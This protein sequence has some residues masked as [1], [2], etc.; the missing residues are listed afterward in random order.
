MFFIFFDW[1]VDFLIFLIF[2]SGKDFLLFHVCFD[3]VY[4]SFLLRDVFFFFFFIFVFSHDCVFSDHFW[5]APLLF[6]D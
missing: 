2:G 6:F 3:F 1:V 4:F 5:P